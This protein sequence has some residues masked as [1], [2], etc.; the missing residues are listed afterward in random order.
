MQDFI[1][2]VTSYCARIYGNRRSKRKTEQLIKE[3]K[4]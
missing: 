3:L 4:E 1:S 2:I